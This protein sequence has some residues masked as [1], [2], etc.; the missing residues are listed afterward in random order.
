[1]T[2]N[3]SANVTDTANPAATQ[4]Q[5]FAS[6]LSGLSTRDVPAAVVH[7]GK[8]A[9]LDAI[10]SALAGCGTAE[11]D[12]VTAA[13]RA[14]GGTGPATVWGTTLTLNAPHAALANG[15]AVHAREVDDF[16]GCGHS[17][18]VVVPAALAAA[19]LRDVSGSDLLLAIIAGYEAAARVIN[20]AGGYAQHNAAGWH[21]TGTCGVFGAAAAAARVLGLNASETAHALAL[22][23][24]YTG[25]IWSFIADGAMSKRLH[26]GK[27]AE[28]GLVAALLAREGMTGPLHVFEGDWGSFTSLYAG[29]K[30]DPAA[31][32]RG[33]GREFLIFQSGFK[34]YA[35]CRGC[36]SSLDAVFQLRER[37]ALELPDIDKVTIHACE[38]LARQLGKQE[39]GNILDAQMSLPYS[40][41]VALTYGRAD[42]EHYQQPHLGDP[43]LATL[44]RRIEVRGEPARHT[45]SEPEVELHLHNGTSV[46]AT[47]QKAKGEHANPLSD[48]ELRQKFFSLATLRVDRARAASIADMVWTLDTLASVAPLQALL[49]FGPEAAP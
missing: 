26:A 35:C 46:H 1:M 29:D 45:G 48:D 49:R 14:W 23:G 2:G 39:V 31:L 13:A 37:H 18:A 16:G 5:R 20:L 6:A 40:V 44:A 38:H 12:R 30:A 24:T 15:T 32:L 41:A 21:G 17:G 27:A 47:V 34:P 4:C 25:G 8:R 42:L 36:H 10:G 22:A 43:A 11:V 28:G 7:G 3:Q 19:E 33:F 9:L